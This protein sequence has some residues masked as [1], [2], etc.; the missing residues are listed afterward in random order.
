MFFMART[1]IPPIQNKSS[2]FCFTPLISRFL[3][4]TMWHYPGQTAIIPINSSATLG[5]HFPWKCLHP[6]QVAHLSATTAQDNRNSFDTTNTI[7][8][9]LD[10]SAGLASDITLYAVI[11]R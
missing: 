11:S 3:S 1:R 7:Q 5:M 6:F 8:S 9:F 2:T 10:V 4:K